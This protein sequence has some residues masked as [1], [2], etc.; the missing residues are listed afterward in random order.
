MVVDAVVDP[1]AGLAEEDEE[2]ADFPVGA[3]GARLLTSTVGASPSSPSSIS[4]LRAVSG[5]PGGTI[6]VRV[7]EDRDVPVADEAE[8]PKRDR[9]IPASSSSFS[10]ARKTTRILPRNKFH[11][12]KLPTALDG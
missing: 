6:D 10:K 2:D 11:D 7:L 12:S 9:A 3:V 5:P 8:D 4:V 1:F